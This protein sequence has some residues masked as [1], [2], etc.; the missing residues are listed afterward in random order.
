[1]K[2][3]YIYFYTQVDSNGE[4]TQHQE[5]PIVN[6]GVSTNPQKHLREI[7]HSDKKSIMV[8]LIKEGKI[9]SLNK[10]IREIEEL[11]VYK[12]WYYLEPL[13]ELIKRKCKEVAFVPYQMKKQKVK[14]VKHEEENVGLASFF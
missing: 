14:V 2:T 12:S 11:R 4:F 5:E 7:S 1:M 9:N 8:M 6:V 13:A 3:H 10:F